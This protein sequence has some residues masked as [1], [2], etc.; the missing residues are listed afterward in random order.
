LTGNNG[1]GKSTLL[2]I[3]AGIYKP[4]TGEI[5]FSA[6]NLTI[7]YLDQEQET[8]DLNQTMINFLS[9]EFKELPEEKIKEELI[10]TGIFKAEE[11]DLP[12]NQISVGCLRKL[13]FIK[14]I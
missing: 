14:L 7:G 2:K 4:L 1:S 11:M 6:D 9:K 13:Q 5:S 3:I 12:L 10:K 8:I